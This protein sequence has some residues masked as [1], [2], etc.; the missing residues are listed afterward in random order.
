MEPSSKRSQLPD[1]PEILDAPDVSPAP[2]RA[3]DMEGPDGAGWSRLGAVGQRRALHAAFRVVAA[4]PDPDGAWARALGL[5]A[6]PISI[7]TR[8]RGP[9]F[10]AYARR[11]ER[12][13]SAGLARAEEGPRTGDTATVVIDICAGP[14]LAAALIVRELAAGRAVRAFAPAALVG[15]LSALAVA[16]D[17]AARDRGGERPLIVHPWT[18]AFELSA[19]ASHSGRVVVATRG[20]GMV[21]D[22][23]GAADERDGAGP[24]LHPLRA[25]TLVL[26]E[27]HDS[28]QAAARVTRLAFGVPAAGGHLSTALGAVW[29]PARRFAEFHAALLDALEGPSAFA[30][31]RCGLAAP[32]R[33]AH[34][35]VRRLGLDEGATL[36]HGGVAPPHPSLHQQHSGGGDGA[37]A[38]SPLVRSVFTNVDPG[39]RL[40]RELD[41]AGVLRVLRVA[42]EDTRDGRLTASAAS[43][44]GADAGVS[45][46]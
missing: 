14:G 1:V 29:V 37:R 38:R 15:G 4:D 44:F 11:L 41:P 16:L 9:G 36:I 25:A 18:G 10:E 27:E 46:R 17:L 22:F 42:A 39:S 34:D 20:S 35:Y 32:L 12:A 24:E 30:T 21:A 5:P 6:G 28:A 33:T 43:A 19:W 26:T 8:R 45:A 3:T 40:L 23:V 13:L 31:L 7:G 2:D